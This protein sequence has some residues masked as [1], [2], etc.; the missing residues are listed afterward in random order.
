MILWYRGSKK[1]SSEVSSDE[2]SNIE[3]DTGD[4]IVSG[5]YDKRLD[6]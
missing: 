2:G 4:I 1:M 6:S 3:E 5:Q